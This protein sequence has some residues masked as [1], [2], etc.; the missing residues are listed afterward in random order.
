[1]Q[2]LEE[3]KAKIENKKTKLIMFKGRFMSISENFF[4][5]EQFF[6]DL[7]YSKYKIDYYKISQN[8]YSVILF[9]ESLFYPNA[10]S[11]FFVKLINLFQDLP[12]YDEGDD[13]KIIYNSLSQ[14]FTTYC[15][16]LLARN[17]FI[18]I[19]SQSSKKEDYDLI[20]Y[21]C[22]LDANIDKRE[23][24][25]NVQMYDVY[26]SKNKSFLEEDLAFIYNIARFMGIDKSIYESIYKEGKIYLR[27]KKSLFFTQL[28]SGN[29]WS[30]LMQKNYVWKDFF[31]EIFE[32]LFMDDEKDSEEEE[33]FTKERKK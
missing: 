28:L 31:K 2:T 10:R 12:I 11:Y 6:I 17:G 23:Y 22:L 26:F 19:T 15:L 30:R 25:Y 20:D 16:K 33:S 3:L 24:D 1:M 7:L 14:S 18:N 5:K 9:F 32:F 4:I 21:V 29:A 27:L 8:P 13:R